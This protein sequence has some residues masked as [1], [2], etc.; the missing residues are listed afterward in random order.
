[1]L[2]LINEL[3]QHKVSV[4]LDEGELNVSYSSDELNPDL[5]SKIKDN[6]QE[7]IAFL[8]K[9]TK[10]DTYLEIP[11]AEEQENYPLSS[12]QYRIWLQ[13]SS[14]EVSIGYNVPNHYSLKGS[15]NIDL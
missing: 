6:K 14:E 15:Y 12:S 11:V 13:C 1:M 9:Y 7:I 2:E 8:Q 4:F 10:T 5:L 3:E